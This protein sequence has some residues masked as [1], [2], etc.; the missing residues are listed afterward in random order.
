[1]CPLFTY[2]RHGGWAIAG[3]VARLLA[4]GGDPLQSESLLLKKRLTW[5]MKR[6]NLFIGIGW[7]AIKKVSC[8]KL[9]RSSQGLYGLNSFF[10]LQ[11]FF[12]EF[13]STVHHWEKMQKPS[14]SPCVLPNDC[15]HLKSYVLLPH[16]TELLTQLLNLSNCRPHLAT[17]C[18]NLQTIQ[19]RKYDAT[20][21]FKE[22]TLTFWLKVG[23]VKR[24]KELKYH[25]TME[26]VSVTL[27]TSCLEARGLNFNL[28]G[29][30][31]APL[32][33][34]QVFFSSLI[35]LSQHCL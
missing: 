25:D 5:E 6:C 27:L 33:L 18:L 15:S 23:C 24:R 9:C 12:Q 16:L 17:V 34:Y 11:H 20:Y 1:M 2:R 13:V 19:I 22:L 28:S 10:K 4:G 14:Y 32:A 29:T 8:A 35:A 31:L 7:G 3:A 26:C 21:S 30:L